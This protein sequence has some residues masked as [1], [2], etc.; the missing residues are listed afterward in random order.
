MPHQCVKCN[1]FYPDGSS[2]L[3]KGCSSCGGKFFFFVRDKDLE[4]AKYFTEN[5]TKEDR[6]QIQQDVFDILGHDSDDQ[7]AVFLD[8][9]SIRILKPGHYELDLVQLFRG[10]PLVY[11]LEDGKYVIDLVSTF[12]SSRKEKEKEDKENK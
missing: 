6:E 8:F 11:K 2:E 10:K 9:E 3:L 12:E 7:E 4:K 5:L 1:T